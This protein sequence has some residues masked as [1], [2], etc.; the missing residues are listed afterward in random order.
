MNARQLGKIKIFRTFVLEEPDG[1]AAAFALLKLVPVRVELLFSEDVF[2][3]TAISE[4]F[5][6]VPDGEMIPEY[7][8]S[9]EAD[10]QGYPF[11]IIV[12]QKSETLGNE[13][14][15][16][17]DKVSREAMCDHDTARLD[18]VPR[19]DELKKGA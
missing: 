16:K 13:F 4:R 12:A 5:N 18:F 19:M 14:F 9:I 3:Y 10:S 15:G 17:I 8:L 1:V 7:S 2:E 6:E 11:E